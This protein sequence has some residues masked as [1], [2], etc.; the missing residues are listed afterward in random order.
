M[1]EIRK[2]LMKRVD[3]L[4][5]VCA[6]LYQ[7]IGTLAHKADVFDHPNVI[8]ALDNASDAALTHKDILPFTLTSTTK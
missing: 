3:E 1:N 2:T 8:K 4:E 7:V 5:T 6:E